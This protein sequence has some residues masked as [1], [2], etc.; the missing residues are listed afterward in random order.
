MIKLNFASD[1]VG[2]VFITNRRKN[3]VDIWVDNHE[4]VSKPTIKYLVAMIY[5]KLSFKGHLDYALE[6]PAKAIS[7]LAKKTPNIGGPQS[8]RRLLIPG[9]AISILLYA[10]PAWARTLGTT[11][12]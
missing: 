4:V 2:A 11:V 9:T 12:N 1:K 3:N 8:S 6:K 5:A 10:A 7:S